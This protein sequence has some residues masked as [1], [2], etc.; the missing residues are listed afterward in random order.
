VFGCVLQVE[1]Q[2]SILKQGLQILQSLVMLC[3]LGTCQ[4]G[5]CLPAIFTLLGVLQHLVQVAH[6]NVTGL[7]HI[8]LLLVQSELFPMYEYIMYSKMF[9]STH[10]LRLSKPVTLSCAALRVAQALDRLLFHLA[11]DLLEAL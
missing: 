5:L 11:E 3:G 8:W 9:C 1:P 4:Q 10:F 6:L 2:Q 7:P